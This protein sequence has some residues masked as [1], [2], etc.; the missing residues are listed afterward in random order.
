MLAACTSGARAPAG[1]GSEADGR[2]AGAGDL[3]V[4]AGFHAA[5]AHGAQALAVLQDRHAA[6][7]HA[8][9]ERGRQEGSAAA[10]DDVLVHLALAAAQGGRAGLAG[11][12]VGR[13]G[14]GTVQ[15]LQR[16]Q[17]AAVVHDGDG[18]R[19]SVAQRFG[20]RGSGDFLD[21]GEFELVFGLHGISE[22][23]NGWRNGR[24]QPRPA[25]TEPAEDIA[26]IALHRAVH[27]KTLH[28]KRSGVAKVI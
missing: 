3:R 27:G 19:P 24:P 12:D 11:G 1:A 16:E 26:R 8:V 4:L 17:V 7:E 21:V 14:S 2:D 10:V 20:L 18:H 25:G 13:Q 6:L 23:E 5:H 22:M 15:A 28:P 9:D